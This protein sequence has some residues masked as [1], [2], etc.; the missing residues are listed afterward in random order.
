MIG[1]GLCV[2]TILLYILPQTMRVRPASTADI[3]RAAHALLPQLTDF[4][5]R[6]PEMF[7]GNTVTEPSQLTLGQPY[8]VFILQPAQAATY[9]TGATL[10]TVLSPAQTWEAVIMLDGVAQGLATLRG[11]QDGLEL[12][13]VASE[14]L[15]AQRL[16]RLP[17]PSDDVSLETIK[18]VGVQQLGITLALIQT[19]NEVK[20]HF[21][22]DIPSYLPEFETETTYSPAEVFPELG[23]Q[24]Q[25]TQGVLQ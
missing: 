25:Q 13:G 7:G 9:Q 17:N 23:Q 3:D 11:D 19:G 6:N 2:L 12:V 15:V 5:Q 8:P 16:A 4:V 14:R 20:L 18:L 10:E 22:S 1:V 24:A 21:L